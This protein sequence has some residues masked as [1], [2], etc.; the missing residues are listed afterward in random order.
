MKSALAQAKLL[1]ALLGSALFLVACGGG[2]ASPAASASVANSAAN[3]G[4]NTNAGIDTAQQM[5][6][7]IVTGF[8][9]IMVDGVEI[10]DAKA[11]T[12]TDDHLGG[13]RTMALRLGQRVEVEHDGAGNASRVTVHAAVIGSASA[14][15]TS[16]LK[17]AGQVVRAN[18]DSGKGAVTAYGGGLT[19]FAD[20]AANVAGLGGVVG[21][22]RHGGL[23][24][25]LGHFGPGCGG[26]TGSTRSAASFGHRLVQPVGGVCSSV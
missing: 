18:T 6:Q 17:V 5:A 13:T 10:E 14:I 7:G 2:G 24:P 4:T 3:N 22:C 16:S 11:S 20:I 19:A 25:G 1:A 8:G 9:S 21:K 12:N 15:S 23:P 26:G